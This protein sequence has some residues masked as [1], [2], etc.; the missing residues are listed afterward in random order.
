[1]PLPEIDANVPC[2]LE[3]PGRIA[4]IGGGPLGIEAALYGRFLGYDVVLL[5]AKQVG[6]AWLA[7][8]DEPLPMLP[9]RSHSPLAAQ[10]LAAQRAASPEPTAAL[11]ITCAGWVNEI[12]LPLTQ[13]DLLSGRVLTGHQVTR[14]EHVALEETLP[15]A[16][17]GLPSAQTNDPPKADDDQADDD[18][19]PDEVP[20]DFAIFYTAESDDDAAEAEKSGLPNQAEAAS[21]QPMIVESILVA[22]TASQAID[23]QCPLPAEYLFDVSAPSVGKTAVQADAE[24]QFFEGLKRIVGVYARLTERPDLDLYRPARLG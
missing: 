11:P 5:E 24:A 7:R 18:D 13:S 19:D 8:G 16:D 14:V 17:S 21:A 3:T 6:H 20:P 23:W 1:M 12:L 2:P 4:V 10:A 22:T 9:D 15:A